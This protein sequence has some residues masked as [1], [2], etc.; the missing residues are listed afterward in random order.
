MGDK[1][2]SDDLVE[3]LRA[4]GVA[5]TVDAPQDSTIVVL[6]PKATRALR[7]DTDRGDA[8]TPTEESPYPE[9]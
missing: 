9:R 3:R 6:G 1:S 2:K 7:T 5:V 8:G 4:R